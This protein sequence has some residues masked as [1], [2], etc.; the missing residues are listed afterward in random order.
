MGMT[1]PGGPGT[2]FPP[3]PG[4]GGAFDCT[5][6]SDCSDGLNGRCVFGRIAMCSY[7]EC[8]EDADCPTGTLCQCGTPT[9]IGHQCMTAE[10]RVDAD[11]PG[12]W[13][14]PTFD[15]CGAYTGVTAYYC[16]TAQDECTNDTDCGGTGQYGEPYCMFEPM[17]GHWVCNDSHC[18]G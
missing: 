10:C 13:C 8:F 6:D 5:E 2:M 16:H 17:V 7:D 14:S 9:G 18:V 12:S 11:C 3:G 4:G 1:C 15:T